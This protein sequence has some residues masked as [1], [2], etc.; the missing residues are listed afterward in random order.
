MTRDE[1][2]ADAE[3]LVSG[4]ARRYTIPAGVD[5]EDVVSAGVLAVVQ[6]AGEY[7]ETTGVPWRAFATQKATW[8]MVDELKHSARRSSVNALKRAQAG[9]L[10]V[11][12]STDPAKV[13]EARDEVLTG[14]T[15]RVARSLPPPGDVAER[16]AKLREVMYAQI[17]EG[18][19][20]A[21]MAAVMGAARDGNIGAAKLVIEL[22]S[23][24][25]AGSKTIVQQAIV[26]NSGDI[27]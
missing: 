22:L 13:A 17:D 14:R 10:A 21:M 6:A 1:L 25:R 15:A 16:V 19:V 3:P 11:Q 27:Q 24:S 12:T 9:E 7:D 26:V 5:R 20:R 4:L 18:G 8:A 23:P 2:I